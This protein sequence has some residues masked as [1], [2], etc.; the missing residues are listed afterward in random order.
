[1]LLA[2]QDRRLRCGLCPKNLGFT[3]EAASPVQPQKGGRVQVHTELGPLSEMVPSYCGGN[4][5]GL[6]V[7]CED[8]RPLA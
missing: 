8:P 4:R 7:E 6:L 1:M 3:V 2:A 5:S